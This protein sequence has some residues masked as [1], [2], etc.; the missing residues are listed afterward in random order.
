M[1]LS[2]TNLSLSVIDFVGVVHVAN[3]RR[4]GF[5]LFPIRSGLTSLRHGISP[6]THHHTLADIRITLGVFQALGDTVALQ[7]VQFIAVPG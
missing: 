1:S 4:I 7:I 5:H 2:P 6:I 3:V